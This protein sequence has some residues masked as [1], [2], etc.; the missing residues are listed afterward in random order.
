MLLRE[1][2]FVALTGK[3]VGGGKSARREASRVEFHQS[4]LLFPIHDGKTRPAELADTSELSRK[5]VTLVVGPTHF[6]TDD[7]FALRLTTAMGEPVLLRCVVRR[8]YPVDSTH[9]SIG[10]EFLTL[11]KDGRARSA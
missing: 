10:A 8:V 5:G 1:D 11:L 4:V 2:L 7:A 6:R 9:H 3:V